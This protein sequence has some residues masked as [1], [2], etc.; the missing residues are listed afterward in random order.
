[1]TPTAVANPN[2][3]ALSLR[4]SRLAALTDDDRRKLAA[5]E[6]DQFRVPARRELVGEDNE[7]WDRRALLSGWA[8]EQRILRNGQRQIL[9]FVLPGDVI[10]PG[11]HRARL[12]TTTILA[13]TDLTM[14]SVPD[15]EGSVG[16]VDGYARGMALKEHHLQAQITRIGR[17]NAYERLADWLLETSDRLALVGLANGDQFAF[18]I[19]QEMLADALGLTSVHV[20]RTLKALH[21]DGLVIVSGKKASLPDRERLAMLVDYRPAGANVTC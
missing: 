15:G 1:M 21:R 8:C 14:C 2:R 13:I 18:P 19:T 12:A 7:Y 3:A 10:G 5:A 16:L 4:L 20:N 6:R 17:M 9:N 11:G